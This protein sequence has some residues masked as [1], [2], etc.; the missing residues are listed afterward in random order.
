MGEGAIIFG[1]K[2]RRK[3]ALGKNLGERNKRNIMFKHNFRW[4]WFFSS[5]L[6]NTEKSS[7]NV[8]GFIVVCIFY[9][10]NDKGIRIEQLLQGG[11]AQTYMRDE[12]VRAR[13][14]RVVDLGDPKPT[15]IEDLKSEIGFQIPGR[16]IIIICYT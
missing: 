6:S 12:H 14:C 15:R 8:I 11:D 7:K 5:V 1:Q 10:A 13:A 16:R 4:L 3:K 2:I 9:R